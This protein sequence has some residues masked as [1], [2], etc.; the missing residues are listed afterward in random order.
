MNFNINSFYFRDVSTSNILTFS[1]CTFLLAK[2]NPIWVDLIPYKI[3]ILV[4]LFLE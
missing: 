4:A 2:E 3:S 1:S